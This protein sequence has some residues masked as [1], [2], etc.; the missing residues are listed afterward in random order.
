MTD[1]R[2]AEAATP[3]SAARRA[4]D[5]LV[6]ESYPELRA[7][8]ARALRDE[9]AATLRP[10]ALVH[11]I[12]LRLAQLTQ[13]EWQGAPHLLAMAT[14]VARQALVDEARRRNRSKRDRG[15]PVTVTLERLDAPAV[16][17]DILEVDDLLR[18]LE[19]I[20]ETAARVVELRVFGGLSVSECAAE[21][22]KSVSTV[23][24]KWRAGRTWL[25]RE[26]AA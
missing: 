21:L 4:L 14:R 2:R 19:G 15:P 8:A 5:D 24:R 12:Y 16:D 13:V 23:N 9:R 6:A 17:C 11:E 22:E 10:T 25:G 1:S 7:V 18:E 3:S 20:D 26:L